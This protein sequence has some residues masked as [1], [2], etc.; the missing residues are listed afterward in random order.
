NAPPPVKLYQHL[1]GVRTRGQVGCE[2]ALADRFHESRVSS[3]PS[4]TLQ[5]HTPNATTQTNSQRLIE[6]R[7]QNESTNGNK[8]YKTTRLQHRD[9]KRKCTEAPIGNITRQTFFF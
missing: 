7:Q 1:L 4:Q 5:T 9:R 8:F 3:Y 2:L 6:E